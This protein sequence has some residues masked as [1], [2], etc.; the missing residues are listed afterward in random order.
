M[1][2]KNFFRYITIGEFIIIGVKQMF[3]FVLLF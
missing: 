1:T 3:K 2:Y